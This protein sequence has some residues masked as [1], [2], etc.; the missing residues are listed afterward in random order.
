MEQPVRLL[1]YREKFGPNSR[2][3]DPEFVPELARDRR[4][5]LLSGDLENQGTRLDALRLA[6]R[7]HK[8]TLICASSSLR[9]C[10]LNAYG[11][12]FTVHWDSILKAAHGPRGGQYHIRFT[13]SQKMR[14]SFEVLECPDGYYHCHGSCVPVD[15]AQKHDGEPQSLSRGARKKAKRIAKYAKQ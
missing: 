7:L 15:P 3:K 2:W 5:V 9:D 1:H 12:H 6:C 14:T 11:P 13:N 10:G 4:W 8:L